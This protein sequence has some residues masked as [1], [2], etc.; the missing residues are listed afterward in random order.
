[1]WFKLLNEEHG[2]ELDGANIN[3][4]DKRNDTGR[5]KAVDRTRDSF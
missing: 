3:R 5:S 1:M 2:M 4:A